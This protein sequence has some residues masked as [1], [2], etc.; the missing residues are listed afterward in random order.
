MCW[1]HLFFPSSDCTKLIKQCKYQ[2]STAT[3]FH[4]VSTPRGAAN[5]DSIHRGSRQNRWK[6]LANLGMA[7]L[8]LPVML[9]HEIQTKNFYRKIVVHKGGEKCNKLSN[10]R[11][12][13]LLR[14]S[15]FNDP[16]LCNTEVSLFLFFGGKLSLY[17]WTTKQ[18]RWAAW[19][20]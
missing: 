2:T 20:W 14:F 9:R 12:K 15:Q 7:W 16:L 3:K 11:K 18:V 19:H 13:L 4:K 6:P 5:T 8:R 10:S 1:V 17:N